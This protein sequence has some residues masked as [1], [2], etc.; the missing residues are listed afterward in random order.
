MLEKQIWEEFPPQ[1]H[2]ICCYISDLPSSASSAPC[3]Q[4]REKWHLFG[5]KPSG[6]QKLGKGGAHSQAETTEKIT[7]SSATLMKLG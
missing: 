7:Q 3:W 6:Q 2:V 4:S 1:C 5:T